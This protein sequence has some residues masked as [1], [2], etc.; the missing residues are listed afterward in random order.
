LR[1]GAERPDQDG[2][3]GQIDLGAGPVGG[4]AGKGYGQ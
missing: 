4:D 2:D 3:I 1:A